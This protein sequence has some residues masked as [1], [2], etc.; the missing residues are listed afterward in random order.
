MRLH[1]SRTGGGQR[2]QK[3]GG[4]FTEDHEVLTRDGFKRIRELNP[5]R[6]RIHSGTYQPSPEIH[7]AVLGML[8][9]DARF[10]RKSNS[11][12]CAHGEHQSDYVYH[13]AKRLGVSASKVRPYSVFLK[14]TQQHHKAMRFHCPVSPYFRWLGERF[15]PEGWKVV[16]ADLLCD[17][18]MISLA[19]LFMDDGHMRFRPSRSPLAEIATCCFREEDLHL[20]IAAISKLGIQGY[21]RSGAARRRIHFDVQNTAILSKLI[22]PYVVESMNYKLLPEHRGIGKTAPRYEVV[23]YFDSFEV[24]SPA[25][26]YTRL[27]RTVYCLGVKGYGNFIT[28]SGVVRNSRP[29]GTCAQQ[30]RA[31]NGGDY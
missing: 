15:Y 19:Y 8:L 16:P 9:G 28:H 23:P 17:F 7:Q 10:D 26:S 24:L 6:D 27:C 12:R 29:P 13:K 22:A 4:V 1:H 14:K 11:F 31:E 18:G 5:L 2:G 21:L 30:P 3:T 20:L 25:P